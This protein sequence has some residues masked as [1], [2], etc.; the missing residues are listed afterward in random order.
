MKLGQIVCRNHNMDQLK[1]GH[2]ESKN[3]SLGQM[4][5]KSWVRSRGNTFSPI[6]MKHDQNIC[7]N[8]ISYEFENQACRIKN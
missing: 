4:L 3:R 1:M 6:L 8:R 5:G 2:V 7:L